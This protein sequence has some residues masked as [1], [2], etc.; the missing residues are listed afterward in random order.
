MAMMYEIMLR[1]FHTNS[2]S[3]GTASTTESNGKQVSPVCIWWN[4]ESKIYS[5]FTIRGVG[6]LLKGDYVDQILGSEN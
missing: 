2:M 3:T 4:N 1:I 5:S 6:R